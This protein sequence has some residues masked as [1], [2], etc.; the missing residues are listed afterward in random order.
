M[1]KR[2]P[3]QHASEHSIQRSCD[4]F[5][6]K[7]EVAMLEIPGYNEAGD[8]IDQHWDMRLDVDHM[9]YEIGIVGTGLSE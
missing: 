5:G 8:S 6:N 1:R 9:S 2:H 3:V 4:L 7:T